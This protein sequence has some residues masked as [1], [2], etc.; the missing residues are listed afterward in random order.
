VPVSGLIVGLGNPGPQYTA[1]RHN[2]GFLVADKL[3]SMFSGVRQVQNNDLGRAWLVSFEEGSSPWTVLKPLTYMNLSGRAVQSFLSH[4][5]LE[6]EKI[7]VLHDELDLPFG[8]IKFKSGGGLA[9]HNGLKSIAECIGSRDF[10]RLR[11][12]I[13]RPPPKWDVARYVLAKM[14]P[15]EYEQL[16]AVIQT[17][18]EAA[19]F[20]CRHGMTAAMQEYHALD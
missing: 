15:W 6:P 2:M 12:G 5:P 8:R 20:F 13:D 3:L 1:T 19:A 17:A 7:L 9:G 10:H 18:A 11:I 4:R 16:P 14:T